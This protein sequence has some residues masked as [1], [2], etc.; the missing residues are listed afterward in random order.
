MAQRK[1][2]RKQPKRRREFRFNCAWCNK[3][4][5]PNVP[6]FGINAKAR[7]EADLT[8][9][10]GQLFEIELL[11]PPRTVPAIVVTSD[12][13]AKREGY[14]MVFMVCSEICSLQLKEAVGRELKVDGGSII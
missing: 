1:L 7:P 12:S 2:R 6:V 5:P 8:E 14:D 11:D 3:T 4:I 13:P 10:E 9:Y